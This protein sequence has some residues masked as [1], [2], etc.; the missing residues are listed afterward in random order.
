MSEQ[1][2]K[3]ILYVQNVCITLLLT[4]VTSSYKKGSLVTR[5]VENA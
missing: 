5:A 1:S 2:N 4:K 3:S